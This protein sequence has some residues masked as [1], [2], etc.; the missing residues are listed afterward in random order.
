MIGVT[1]TRIARLESEGK[2]ELKRTWAWN[3]LYTRADLARQIEMPGDRYL[4][5]GEWMEPDF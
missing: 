3:I 5:R 2:R 1:Q 4:A